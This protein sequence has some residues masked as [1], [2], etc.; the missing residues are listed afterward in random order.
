MD[1][2]NQHAKNMPVTICDSIKAR[3]KYLHDTHGN[4]FRDI[5]KNPEFSPIPAGTLCAI[6]NGAEVPE[7]W[8]ERLGLPPLALA[9]VCPKHGVVH[10]SKRCPA[11]A[12]QKPRWVRVMGHQG[13]VQL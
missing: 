10:T 7:K 8:R 13:S 12:K 2:S 4:T 11:E 9:P 1:K 3:L 5:A 6:Y